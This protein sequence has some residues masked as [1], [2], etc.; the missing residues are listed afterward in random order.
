MRLRAESTAQKPDVAIRQITRGG[1]CGAG[2][3]RWNA[4]HEY[5]SATGSHARGLGAGCSAGRSACPWPRRSPRCLPL[6]VLEPP[7]AHAS[8]LRSSAGRSEVGLATGRRGPQAYDPGSQPYR[9]LSGDCLRVLTSLRWVK[10]GLPQRTQ[11]EHLRKLSFSVASCGTISAINRSTPQI[12]LKKPI[13]MQQNGW[14]PHGK[15]LASGNAVSE[16]N[17]ARRRSEDGGS[18]SCLGGLHGLSSARRS[19]AVAGRLRFAYDHPVHT[20]V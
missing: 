15:L 8:R 4:R 18:T 14:Q 16:W 6:E 13:G 17:G 10:L 5:A 1:L 3:T 20:C 9:R 2:W 7:A 11:P 12:T 19:R